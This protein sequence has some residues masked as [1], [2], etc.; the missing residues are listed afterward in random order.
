M[1]RKE[2]IES[3]AILCGE[4]IGFIVGAD[5]ADRHPKEGLVSIDKVCE[6]LNDHIDDYGQAGH[7]RYDD[8]I[9]DLRKEMEK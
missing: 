5:W 6:W 3:A 1:T 4:P 8:L 2:Q 9:A 7:D